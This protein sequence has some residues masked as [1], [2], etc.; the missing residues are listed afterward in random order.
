[1]ATELEDMLTKFSPVNCTHCFAHILNLVA[2]S[3]LKQFDVKKDDKKEEDL[4]NDEQTLL[5]MAGDIEQEEMI[6]AQE[7]DDAD[8]KVE[9]DDDLEGWV[10]EVEAL[11]AEEQENLNESIW[12]VKKMLVKVK[13]N[14]NVLVC[15]NGSIYVASKTCL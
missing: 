15:P 1:M 12:P 3:L 6:S 4:N 7:Q 2:K 13:K 5:A 8:S 14:W 9:D 11:S 10:D